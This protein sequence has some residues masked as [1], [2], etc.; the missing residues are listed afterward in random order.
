MIVYSVETTGATKR[1]V[2]HPPTSN[3]SPDDDDPMHPDQHGNVPPDEP[4]DGADV[5][6]PDEPDDPLDD[7]YQ[8]DYQTGPDPDDAD[9]DEEYIIPDD[10]GPPPGDDMDMPG[11][12]QDSGEM[13][14]IEFFTINSLFES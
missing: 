10:S 6:I 5:P 12:A 4:D 3:D 7:D 14:P 2:T 9:N 11:V 1:R 8:P 13:I